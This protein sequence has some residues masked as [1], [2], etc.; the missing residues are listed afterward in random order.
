MTQHEISTVSIVDSRIADLTPEIK[1]GVYNGSRNSTYQAF[2]FNSASNTSLS[3]NIQIPSQS[4]CSDARVLWQSDL[5]LTIQCSNVPIGKSSLS[6]GVTDSLAPYPLQS[7]LQTAQI[8]INN[9]QV[10]TNYRDILPFAKLLEDKADLDKINSTSPDYVN[11]FWGSFGDAVLS[12]S[13]PM[14][15]YNDCSQ[16]NSRIPNGAYPATFIVNHYIAGVLTDSSLISTAT[17]DT[18]IIY[19]TFKQLSEPF[20]ALS[21]FISNDFNRAGLIGLNA[22]AMTLTINDCSRV[23]NTGNVTVTSTGYSSYINSITLGTPA[24][25]GLGFTNARLLFN[26]L[27]LSDIQ[28]SQIST[29]NVTNYMA[30]DRY[31]S[32]SSNSPIMTANTGGY[33]ISCQNLQLNQV[34]QYIVVGIRV[35]SS[36]QN[37]AYPDSFLTINNV[38]ITWNN[39]SGLLSSASQSQLFNVSKNAGSKQSFYSFRGTANAVQSGVAV[40]IATLGSM[41][42]INPARDLSMD[43]MLSNSSIGQF[44]LQIQLNNVFNQYGFQVQPEVVIGIFNAGVIVTELGSSQIFSALLN[45]EMVLNSK[46]E[47][48]GENAIDEM[49]YEKT[50]GGAMSRGM[51]TCSKVHRV[52]RKSPRHHPKKEGGRHIGKGKLNSLVK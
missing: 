19:A 37:W 36:Q 5:N 24:S 3:A 30:Y 51:A 12:N 25:S 1:F 15:N 50:V 10:S 38:S 42:V 32:P 11:E 39:A 31:I 46:E 40:N 45:R 28:Y 4:V 9:A 41:L 44:N 35:P 33:T 27:T 49:L 20:L 21:P 17:T 52:H 8:S 2:P 16:D 29:R 26:F 7:L 34:P 48:H 18:W 14:G 6:Y 22:I 23:W 47:L 43:A 13:S